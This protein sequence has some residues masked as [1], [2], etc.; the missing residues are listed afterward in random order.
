MG[1]GLGGPGGPEGCG[2]D[3]GWAWGWML[4]GGTSPFTDSMSSARLHTAYCVL[5]LPGPP[6]VRRLSA[7]ARPACSLIAAPE[8]IHVLCQR[9]PRLKLITSEID[10]RVDEYFRVV[11]GVGNVSRMHACLP[12]RLRGAGGWFGGWV[13]WCMHWLLC[14]CALPWQRPR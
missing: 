1:G 13:Q 11:P 6:C 3:V 10:E 4:L 5:P 2:W 14:V 7:P 9:F 8:G 12:A